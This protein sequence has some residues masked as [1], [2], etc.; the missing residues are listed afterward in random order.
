MDISETDIKT[1]V[2]YLSDAAVL[3]SKMD[4]TVAFN[5]A[6]LINN[7]LRKIKRK[8]ENYDKLCRAA[9]QKPQDAQTE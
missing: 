8:Q 3:Y 6:R 5:R 7:L 9:C 1:I 4:G 2:R